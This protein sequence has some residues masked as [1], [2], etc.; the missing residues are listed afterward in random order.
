[1]KHKK[2]NARR[3]IDWEMVVKE[4]NKEIKSL[5]TRLDRRGEWMEKAIIELEQ[6]DKV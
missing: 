5:K 6:K 3:F 1:M 4:K 2:L